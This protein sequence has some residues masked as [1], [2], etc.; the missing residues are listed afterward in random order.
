VSEWDRRQ[1]C[2]DGS[3]VG[4]IGDDGRCKVCGRVAPG[5][6]DER[7]RGLEV[8]EDD[9]EGEED[10]ELDEEPI[11][12]IAP[13][14][15]AALGELAEWQKRQLCPDG[16]CIGVIGSDGRCKV[17]GK[18]ATAEAKE[19]EQVATELAAVATDAEIDD[20][21]DDHRQLCPDGACVGVIGPDGKCKV[22][23]KEAAA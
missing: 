13:S 3:C 15:P 14:A 17:C 6:G 16:T 11:D 4:V 22:C 9:D 8:A 12:E 10:D 7:N 19:L 2:P 20:D 23:G 1:L 5:W 21:D 18:A